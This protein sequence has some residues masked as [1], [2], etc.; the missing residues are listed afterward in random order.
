MKLFKVP[1]NKS[2]P[3]CKD[4]A[5][6]ELIFF[7]RFG[8][9]KIAD[10]NSPLLNVRSISKFTGVSESTVAKIIKKAPSVF[11]GNAAADASRHKRLQLHHVS[12]LI[13]P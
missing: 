5:L 10:A 9:N 11:R 7:L 3:L 13:S 8:V 1:K 4:N 6:A 2:L 12:Y